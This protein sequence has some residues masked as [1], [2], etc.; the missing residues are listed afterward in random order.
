MYSSMRTHSSKSFRKLSLGLPS[1]AGW[2]HIY[3]SMRTHIQYEDTHMVV[4]RH[5]CSSMRNHEAVWRRI[6][7]SMR[8]HIQLRTHATKKR[9]GWDGHELHETEAGVVSPSHLKGL[10]ELLTL[11]RLYL[12]ALSRR[13][14]GSILYQGALKALCFMKHMY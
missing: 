12:K 1:G 6:H 2:G 9:G 3:G 10:R 13:Y 7:S 4:W 14:Y 11:L 8:T 5:I